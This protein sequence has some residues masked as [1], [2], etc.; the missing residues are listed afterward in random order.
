MQQDQQPR[1]G[2]AQPGARRPLTPQEVARR[3]KKREQ[4]KKALRRYHLFL[5]GFAL[6]AVALL[7]GLFF[8]VKGLA[9]GGE[10]AKTSPDSVKSSA[11]SA[12]PAS[13]AEPE[14]E[15][16]PDPNAPADPA[17]WSLLLT[18]VSHPLPDG[19]APELASVGSN[20]RNGQQFMDERVA[21]AMLQMVAA[22]KQDGVDLVVRS[23]YR[24][25]QEQASLFNS[26]K[27][28]YLNQGLSEEQ[29]LAETKKWRNVPGTS[30]HETGLCADIVGAA[31][32]N[33]DLV[34]GLSEREWAKWLKEHAA[35]YGFILRYPEDKTGV[36]GTSFEPWHYRYVGVEDARKIM[37]QGV[38]LEEYLGAA[39]E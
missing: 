37:S 6:L 14:P 26:M 3:R 25:T 18:N 15:P 39:G 38:C 21:D 28:S 4:R 9:A 7:V 22:A 12:P 17:L 34:P 8:M 32:L 11:S 30:E 33:A 20:S 5:A 31:D 2:A 13:S 16:A 36:T 1:R 27:Q 19:Y 24:S 23:A 29:A 10:G 35:D